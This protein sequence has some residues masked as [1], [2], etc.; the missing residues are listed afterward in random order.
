M[1]HYR[2]GRGHFPTCRPP[3]KHLVELGRGIG[4]VGEIE[5]LRS[6]VTKGHYELNQVA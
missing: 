1:V 2:S 4:L 3:T 5:V 6:A